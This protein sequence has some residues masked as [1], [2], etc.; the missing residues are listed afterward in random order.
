MKY[1]HLFA[2]DMDYTLLLP[3][4]DI[5]K[6]NLEAIKALDE[7]G[8]AFTLS[9]GRSSYLTTKYA[10]ALDIKV[11]IITS[12]GGALYDYSLHKDIYSNDFSEECLRAQLKLIFE[13]N[14]DA[15]GYSSSGLY[16]SKDS[17]RGE[18]LNNYNSTEPEYD[19]IPLFDLTPEI[20][21]RE[22][23]PAFNKFL[24]ISP[25]SDVLS[26]FQAMPELE[27]VSSAKDFQDIMCA[28]ATKGNALMVLADKMGIPRGN[29][30]AIGD[31]DND[32]SMLSAAGTAIAM[33]NST[34]EVLKVADY[35]TDIC[36]NDGFA[37]AIFEIVLPMVKGS[38]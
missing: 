20:L 28:G 10:R 23:I 31:A 33:G 2:T 12:N 36:E 37:K 38:K 19:K 3:G 32:L 29:T 7:A 34:P 16:L 18:F 24:L 11:P 21:E 15:T 25:P 26:K 1:T 5:S 14:L 22:D 8:V 17:S 4:K 27:V 6:E 35:V 30:F 9:T 13:N